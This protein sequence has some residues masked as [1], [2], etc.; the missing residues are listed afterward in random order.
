MSIASD[1]LYN[2]N[3][4]SN[5]ELLSSDLCL[6]NVKGIITFYIHFYLKYLGKSFLR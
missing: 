1:T 2:E 4:F 6:R 5:E 3:R